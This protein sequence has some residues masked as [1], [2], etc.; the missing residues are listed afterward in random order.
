MHKISVV[1]LS[2]SILFQSFSFDLD[3]FDMLPTLV[4]HIKCHLEIGDNF[5]DF[6]T[7]HYGSELNNHK[8]EH[9]EHDKLPFKHEH[10]EAHFQIDYALYTDPDMVYLK[11]VSFKKNR[12]S[13]KDP[14]TNLFVTTFFQPPQK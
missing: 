14:S 1:I 8:D 4:N 13:Y 9:K 3:D 7:M 6:I 10:L 12:F 2:F 5:G 11:D